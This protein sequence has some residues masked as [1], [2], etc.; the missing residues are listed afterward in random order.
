MVDSAGN[1][2]E[3]DD[4]IERL[5]GANA[6]YS[7]LISDLSSLETQALQERHPDMEPEDVAREFFQAQAL[8]LEAKYFAGESRIVVAVHGEPDGTFHAHL[9]LPGDEETLREALAGERQRNLEG[10]H[11][12]AQAAFDR[13]WSKDMT[14]GLDRQEY[15]RAMAEQQTY[16][17]QVSVLRKEAYAL[18]KDTTERVKATAMADGK[19][20]LEIQRE[21][22]EKERAL[23]DKIHALE[24]ERIDKFWER[25]GKSQSLEHLV[26]LEREEF[27]YR[28]DA[29]RADARIA[30]V[31]VALARQSSVGDREA[32][33]H[34]T[35]TQRAK[36]RE[37]ALARE[38]T[39]VRTKHEIQV[40][41]LDPKSAE[42]AERVARQ[43][44]EI[45]G[46]LLRHEAAKLGDREHDLGQLGR[47]KGRAVASVLRRQIQAKR[48]DLERQ[49][50]V[51]RS[52]GMGRDPREEAVA[53][54][55]TRQ[56]GERQTLRTGAAK[57]VAQR[58][59]AS[60]KRV[61]TGVARV[62]GR[63]LQKMSE[64]LRKMSPRGPRHGLQR[65]AGHV[66][67]T[68]QSVGLG[69]AAGVAKVASTAAVEAARAALHQ[70]QH[71]AD[72]ARVTAKALATGVINPL[73]GA[74]EA[75]TGYSR[76]GA[77]SAKT[78][79]KDL[80]S[81]TKKVAR[82]VG[83]TAKGTASQ[84][85]GGLASLGANAAPQEVQA[86][87]DTARTALVEAAKTSI[88]ATRRA[89]QGAVTLN[90]VEAV[91][92]SAVEGGK[93]LLQGSMQLVK[94]SKILPSAKLPAVVEKPLEIAEKIPV[95][96]LAVQA[97]HV[98]AKV[99]HGVSK[100]GP[101]LDR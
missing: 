38:L 73:V 86:V 71:A 87:V 51:A 9:L 20:R 83:A 55:E 42:Y 75:G 93:G 15:A 6:P 39:A 41:D 57:G 58:G 34:M 24:V 7:E 47:G 13:A 100:S 59:V 27:R 62:P 35:A 23:A 43:E 63:I 67:R 74:K 26:Y 96:G 32:F 66:E 49:A 3:I 72:A 48:H 56:A 28:G 29:R 98:A 25:A 69:A 61:V 14:L 65:E 31:N 85:L 33:R 44:H 90:P 70:A 12:Q 88:Q 2:L 21:A 37:E 17:A 19:A 84:T 101:E 22:G 78:A 99:A 76:I 91:L 68:A 54:L 46:I 1:A 11:G 94:T 80:V 16:R 92:G 5:G 64:D 77:E 60:G 79:G 82:D 52:Q 45:R 36:V 18:Q 30:G 81:G 97:I 8:E 40:R 10:Q 95:L 50:L 89:I 53:K 4:A